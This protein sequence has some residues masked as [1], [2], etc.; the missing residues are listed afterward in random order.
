[1]RQAESLLSKISL[2]SGR[3]TYGNNKKD[4]PCDRRLY[5]ISLAY[6][7]IN[8][9]WFNLVVPVYW[10]Y[11]HA[12]H[13]NICCVSSPIIFPRTLRS[14]YHICSIDERTGPHV[15]WPFAGAESR[16]ADLI[17]FT[18]QQHLHIHHRPGCWK[19]AERLEAHNA[20]LSCDVTDGSWPPRSIVLLIFQSLLSDRC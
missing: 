1:V 11:P 2:F 16:L 5:N 8:F 7:N 14:S 19:G 12:R 17:L 6:Q 10:H 9:I 13:W 18:A 15:G 4:N 3:T 20:H